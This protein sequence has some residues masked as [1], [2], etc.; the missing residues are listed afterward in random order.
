MALTI[1]L[2]LLSTSVWRTTANAVPAPEAQITPAPILQ[3]QNNA[4]FIGYS[5]TNGTCKSEN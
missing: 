2:A 4:A 5:S 3:R 1:S